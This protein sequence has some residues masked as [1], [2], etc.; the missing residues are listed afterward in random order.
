MNDIGL[1]VC[2]LKLVLMARQISD[3]YWI[4]CVRIKACFNEWI[5]RLDLTF[6]TMQ[7]QRLWFLEGNAIGFDLSNYAKAKAVVCGRKCDWI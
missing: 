7:K 3:R 2:E 1:N 5:M 4:K 6:P